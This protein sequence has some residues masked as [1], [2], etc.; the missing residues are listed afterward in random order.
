[1]D[2]L[3]DKYKSNKNQSGFFSAVLHTVRG[4]VRRLVGF[5]ALTEEDRLKA[6]IYNGSKGPDR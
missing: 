4:F 5:F 3:A 1:M 6:G 2:I